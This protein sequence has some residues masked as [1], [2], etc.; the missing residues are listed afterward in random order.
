MGELKKIFF[1]LLNALPLP[2]NKYALPPS[3]H[4]RQ[5][6]CRC[7]RTATTALLLPTPPPPPPPPRRPCHTAAAD[8]AFVSI[9]IA[10]AVIIAISVVVAVA[11]FC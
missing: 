5:A 9:V 11:A 8:I 2:P 7:R 1:R 10:V 4:R 3:C 6:G